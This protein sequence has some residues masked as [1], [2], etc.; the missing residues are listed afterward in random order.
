[1]RNAIVQGWCQ[2]A[3]DLENHVIAEIV[4]APKAESIMRLPALAV[5]VQG[6]I[7][8]SN[9]P[10]FKLQAENFIKSINTDLQTDEDFAQAAA[11]VA[12]ETRD[13]INQFRQV[14][15]A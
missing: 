6:S 10:D 3:E 9:L 11:R 7:V 1:M 4:E 15:S 14:P 13:A 5:Q 2:F 8:A 12:R